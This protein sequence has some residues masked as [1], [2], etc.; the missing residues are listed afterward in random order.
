MTIWRAVRRSRV[1]LF[2]SIVIAAVGPIYL[3]I[4]FPFIWGR[5]MEMMAMAAAPN[6][7]EEVLFDAL[8]QQVTLNFFGWLVPIALVIAAVLFLVLRHFARGD[9]I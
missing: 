7:S 9:E 1:A 6:P 3:V 8:L 2:A 5:Q 4:A